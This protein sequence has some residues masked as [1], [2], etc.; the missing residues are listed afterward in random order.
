MRRR[1]AV[2][3]LFLC[4]VVT[5]TVVMLRQ[6]VISQELPITQAATGMRANTPELRADAGTFPVTLFPTDDP[7]AWIPIEPTPGVQDLSEFSRAY[8]QYPIFFENDVTGILTGICPNVSHIADEFAI[9]LPPSSEST[10]S[11]DLITALDRANIGHANTGYNIFLCSGEYPIDRTLE[12]FT[13]TTV[14][15]G[16]GGSASIFRYNA[17]PSAA[18]GM[19]SVNGEANVTFRNVIF[20]GWPLIQ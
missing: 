6:N 19:F 9:V 1:F 15:G 12:F 4:I 13:T 10:T 14:Y 11:T 18:G 17:E 5:F 8:T 7:N 2:F 16:V 20:S 3:L